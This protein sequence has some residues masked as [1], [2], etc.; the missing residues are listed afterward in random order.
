MSPHSRN[1]HTHFSCTVRERERARLPVY[2]RG[3]SPLNARVC[4]CGLCG[5]WREKS[6]LHRRRS[7]KKAREQ[8]N[9]AVLIHRTTNLAYMRFH[10]T[11]KL[12]RT[13]LLGTQKSSRSFSQVPPFFFS[14][15]VDRPMS[16]WPPGTE[17]QNQRRRRRLN[18]ARCVFSDFPRIIGGASLPPMASRQKRYIQL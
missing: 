5:R 18:C 3:K 2:H 10:K 9:C 16:R 7:S 13:S 12:P 11:P 1:F 14:P 8:A 6:D 17:L 4:V 15:P